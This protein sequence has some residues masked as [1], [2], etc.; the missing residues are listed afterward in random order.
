MKALASLVFGLGI[1][2]AISGAAKVAPQPGAWPNTLPTFFAG[3]ALALLA[4][5]I[6]RAKTAKAVAANATSTKTASIENPLVSLNNLSNA[7]CLLEQKAS[8][9]NNDEF[10]KQIE[11]LTERHLTPF[12]ESKNQI[13]AQLGL[14]KG[15]ELIIA[16]AS[17]ERLLNRAWSAA[18][19]GHK[20]EAEKSLRHAT[21]ALKDASRLV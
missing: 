18:A 6:W 2:I 17:G 20:F 4:L 21:Q 5:I 3:A 1:I 9:L 16:T 8:T 10:C 7:A 12:V 19:D 15:S 13:I 14:N 11:E